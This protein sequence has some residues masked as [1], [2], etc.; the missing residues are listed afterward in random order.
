MVIA[1]TNTLWLIAGVLA[2]VVAMI[3]LGIRSSVKKSGEA[4]R[5]QNRQLH[6]EVKNLKATQGS[7]TNQ[8]ADLR[9]RAVVEALYRA[10]ALGEATDPASRRQLRTLSTTLSRSCSWPTRLQS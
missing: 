10:P 8:E 6:L 5:A 4:L 3:G 7:G 1:D 2:F 9:K